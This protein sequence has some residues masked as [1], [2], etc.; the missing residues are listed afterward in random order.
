MRKFLFII[1]VFAITFIAGC[2]EKTD[3]SKPVQKEKISATELY[4]KLQEASKEGNL[5][6][7][8]TLITQG[9]D[10]NL[11]V[12]DKT[13]GEDINDIEAQYKETP[14]M[15]ASREGHL[16]VVKELIQAGAKVNQILPI[17]TDRGMMPGEDQTALEKACR[18][19]NTEVLKTLAEAGTNAKD[20]L[21]CACKIGSE[22]LLEIALTNKPNLNFTTGE[23]G[24]SPLIMAV[25]KGYENIVKA[26]L[27]AGADPNYT[28][29]FEPDYTALK[30]AKEKGNE[31]IVNILKAA[32]AK[33][34]NAEISP[35][36][37][38]E[39]EDYIEDNYMP[40]SESYELVKA[41]C[42]GNNQLVK[43][44][45]EKDASNIN[46]ES[47][48]I[49]LE[50]EHTPLSCALNGTYK[51]GYTPKHRE[52]VKTLVAFGADV[53]QPDPSG[54]DPMYCTPLQLA[55]L[56]NDTQIAHLLVANG[57]D[58]NLKVKE[59]YCSDAMEIAE[60]NKNKI[61]IALLKAT[62]VE[63][64]LIAASENGEFEKVKKLLDEDAKRAIQIT[65]DT[66]VLIWA[67]REGHTKLVKALLEMGMKVD[68]TTDNDDTGS[69][70]LMYSVSKGHIDV[71]KLLL[72]AG[73]DVNIVPT[74]TYPAL[75]S[76]ATEGRKEIL[77]LLLNAGADVNIKDEEGNTALK[78]AQK[79]GNEEIVKLLKAAGAKE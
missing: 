44:I 46:K 21:I 56:R 73:A 63:K 34:G 8:R 49:E 59:G 33:D 24:V 20:I 41:A 23:G 10:V 25:E 54:Q 65:E 62:K 18:S 14:L 58:V 1:S 35:S 11:L 50:T 9:A 7:V 38:S 37:S 31:E 52:V 70:A 64:E 29:P 13:T 32:G 3:T 47:F 78:L 26:L 27:K 53:N 69:T 5:N 48:I 57:A 42:Y 68:E 75:I 77:K 72:D 19:D 22:E 76:A 40:P 67:A 61:I 79:A 55:V 4:S 17:H 71:V 39:I 60:K 74:Y 30:A 66:T 12:F 15:L 51:E 28:D 16:A 2:S 43:E 36:D 6:K 45:L